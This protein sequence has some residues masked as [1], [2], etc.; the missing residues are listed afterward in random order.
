SP[1][2]KSTSEF[3]NIHPKSHRTCRT[4]SYNNES[5]R[6]PVPDDKVPWNVIYNDYEPFEY[7]AERIRQNPK[8]DP[9]DPSKINKFNQLD[10]NIDRR[11]FTG[12]Y[13]IDP[14]TYRPRNPIGRTGLTGRGRLYYWG[15]NHAGD[16]VITRWLRDENGSIVYRR[17]NA[18][19]RLKPILEFVAIQRK[20]NKEW[21]LPGVRKVLL[22]KKRKI[23]VAIKP[24]TVRT[25]R[26]DFG[27]ILLNSLVDFLRGDYIFI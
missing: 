15:P 17:I 4:L 13:Y 18:H 11:S 16:P 27:C 21:A 26:W 2:R 8:T 14:I 3:N 23:H 9:I 20:D 24:K 19:D 25:N 22:D 12:H 7:T 6:F 5:E 1:R 10:K